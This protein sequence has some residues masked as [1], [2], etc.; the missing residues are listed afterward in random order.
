MGSI[1]RKGHWAHVPRHTYESVHRVLIGLCTYTLCACPLH[2]PATEVAR[3]HSYSH[4][5]WWHFYLWARANGAS[6]HPVRM[7]R[8]SMRAVLLSSNLAASGCTS[9]TLSQGCA[10]GHHRRPLIDHTNSCRPHTPR[11]IINDANLC[12]ICGTLS[13]VQWGADTAR[14]HPTRANNI[15]VSRLTFVFS[16]D[17]NNRLG[18]NTLVRGTTDATAAVCARL[19]RPAACPALFTFDYTV[20]YCSLIKVAA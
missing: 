10:G 7:R 2:T 8:P 6:P 14:A 15:F 9:T 16:S 19:A 5:R 17:N 20:L 4:T 13:A 1:N 11:G 3:V 18:A 12:A